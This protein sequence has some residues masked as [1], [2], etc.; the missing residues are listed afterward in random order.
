MRTVLSS[1]PAHPH[2]P[3]TIRLLMPQWQGGSN[4]AY[5]LG[6]RL[7]AW[8]APDSEAPLVEV[9]VE[10]DD[11]TP[12]ELEGGILA[13]RALLRQLA[14]ARELIEA[15]APDRIIVFGGDCLVEQAPFAYLNQR[16]GGKLG[17]LWIDAHPDVA[18]PNERQTGHTMVLGS[19]LGQ[20][21]SE[22]AATVAV[23]LAP[24]RVMLAGLGR[25]SEQEAA[26]I[27]RHA[28]RCASAAELAAGNGAVLDW[29][30]EA[31]IEHLAIHLDL[32]V[33]DPTLF[34]A[35]GFAKPQTDPAVAATLRNGAMNFDEI[36]GLIADV[37]ARTDV[38]ALGITEHLPWDAVNL[39][40]ML[41]RIPILAG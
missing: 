37:S 12:A 41:G 13:R 40:N 19:L 34:R 5:G 32:D 3:K 1:S 16:Y 17:V 8:L 31:G 26:F 36:V 15:E 30:A 25:L 38:V 24:E 7:L 27:E 18:T 33:L 14:A 11:G 22:F 28:L 39:Q 9:P 20:G 35:L 29:I 10:A 4:P 2:A 6:A 21:D 23:P